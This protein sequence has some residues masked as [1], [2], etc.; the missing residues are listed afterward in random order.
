MLAESVW[1]AGY[2]PHPS[3][4][5]FHQSIIRTKPMTL[6]E[7]AD[8]CRPAKS[9]VLGLT[10]LVKAVIVSVGLVQPRRRT[11][12]QLLRDGVVG[13]HG[14]MVFIDRAASGMDAG[15]ISLR[16]GDTSER[17][18]GAARH[19]RRRVT[20]GIVAPVPLA[21]SSRIFQ[22]QLLKQ[23]VVVLQGVVNL[24]VVVQHLLIVSGGG[25]RSSSG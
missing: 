14:R 25:G 3:T 15:S 17:R 19:H 21:V 11:A 1:S 7:R 10:Y 24:L 12:N 4:I 23:R 13:Q 2:Y 18:P 5:D 22:P 20:L 6:M 9:K 16:S 8:Y